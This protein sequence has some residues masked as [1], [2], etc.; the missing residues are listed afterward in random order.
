MLAG[1]IRLVF[2][3]VSVLL[4]ASCTTPSAQGDDRL[5]VVASM[6]IIADLAERVVGEHAMVT[7]LV[8]IG[9]DPHLHEP[10]PSDARQLQH[11]DLV[12]VNGAG[13]EPWLDA[14]LAGSGHEAVYL[15]EQLGD[16]VELDEDG[17]LDPHLWMAP[18]FAAVYV[19]TISARLAEL[20]PANADTYRS[21]AAAFL[22]ELAALDHELEES[23][24]RI[25]QDRRVLVTSHDAYRYF[26]DHYG[27]EVVA[28]VGVST[29]EEPSAARVRSVVDSIRRHDIP[30][31]FVETTINPAVMERIALD[32]DVEVGRPLYGDSVG[33]QGTQADNYVGMM[34]ANVDALVEG[35]VRR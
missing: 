6:S 1:P 18:P 9:G 20:D 28:V 2:A 15:S 32:A 17:Q 23:L 24:A 26:A 3:A 5:R 27:L 8:P 29:E 25:P 30:T 14:L 31:V 19:E 12:L 22:E 11:A 7:S 10:S 13:L 16:V 33:E 4:L 21:N 34:R 35:L